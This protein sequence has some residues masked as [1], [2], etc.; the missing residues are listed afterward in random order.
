MRPIVLLGN[1]FFFF[2]VDSSTVNTNSHTQ[3]Q[4]ACSAIRNVNCWLEQ[5]FFAFSV[6]RLTNAERNSGN[7]HR[8]QRRIGSLATIY[9][10]SHQHP[11]VVC[12][13]YYFGTNNYRFNCSSFVLKATR[14]NGHLPEE[15]HTNIKDSLVFQ[16]ATNGLLC[17]M[18]GRN[19]VCKT[20]FFSHNLF[21]IKSTLR[22]AHSI[23]CS[24]WFT[25]A[26]HKHIFYIIANCN[27]R[28]TN[29]VGFGFICNRTTI[30]CL[31][32][33]VVVCGSSII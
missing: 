13:I 4:K 15:P 11:S 14:N 28:E 22:L 17:S 20:Q 10:L 3:L 24:V 6:A 29:F 25:N 1:E 19:Y 8:K 9:S 18:G 31:I 2:F 21:G 30:S 7:E 12:C 27:E 23:Q 32:F 16:S 33:C 5:P 26:M